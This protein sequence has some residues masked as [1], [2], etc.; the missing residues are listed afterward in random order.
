MPIHSGGWI[1]FGEG[2]KKGKKKPT[3]ALKRHTLQK[4]EHTSMPRERNIHREPEHVMHISS[5]Q[6]ERKV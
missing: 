3:H 5:E 4:E 1:I 6:Q 2:H